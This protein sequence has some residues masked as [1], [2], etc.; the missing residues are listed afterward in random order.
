MEMTETM[1]KVVEQ[2]KERCPK[3]T[4]KF[5]HPR[6]GIEESKDDCGNTKKKRR[7]KNTLYHCLNTKEAE[8][9]Q[10]EWNDFH[11]GINYQNF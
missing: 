4:F 9:V 10:A 1:Q 5:L 3:N 11:R 7:R 6:P 8:S 2:Y